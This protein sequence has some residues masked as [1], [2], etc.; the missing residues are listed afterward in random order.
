LTLWLPP[1]GGE[2]WGGGTQR[3]GDCHFNRLTNLFDHEP[4]IL[5]HFV[6][7]KTQDAV[8][9][10]HEPSSP[11]RIVL[12][13]ILLEM[14]GPVEFDDQ[15]LGK[16]D[17]VDD[18]RAEREL[19]AKL[20]AIELSRSEEYSVGKQWSAVARAQFERTIPRSRRI[21]SPRCPRGG[22]A[23]ALTRRLDNGSAGASGSS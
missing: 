8:T 20:V 16:A 2:G 10:F 21:G 6:I 1:L 14:L 18:V 23:S 7:A 17:E 19:P 3:S 12:D 4:H 22:V 11:P 5:V 9:A 15:A 13:R